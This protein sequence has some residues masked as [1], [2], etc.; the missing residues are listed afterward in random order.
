MFSL[1]IL[2]SPNTSM[3]NNVQHWQELQTV[4]GQ[5]GSHQHVLSHTGPLWDEEDSWSEHSP[6]TGPGRLQKPTIL[7]S[8]NQVCCVA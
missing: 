8:E 1:I 5:A 4:T 7:P 3:S 2:T 6:W